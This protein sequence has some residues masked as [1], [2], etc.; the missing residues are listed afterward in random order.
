MTLK[1]LQTELEKE[2]HGKAKVLNILKEPSYIPSLHLL[3]KQTDKTKE[4]HYLK[5]IIGDGKIIVFAFHHFYLLAQVLVK[6]SELRAEIRKRVNMGELKKFAEKETDIVSMEFKNMTT[7][8]CDIAIKWKPKLYSSFC[9]NLKKLFLS[10][11]TI[12]SIKCF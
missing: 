9:E 10:N 4:L 8:L 5:D 3:K 6:G 11:G 7:E 2:T 12:E 1:D